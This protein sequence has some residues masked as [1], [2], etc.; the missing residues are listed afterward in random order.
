MA[1]KHHEWFVWTKDA[2]ANEAVSRFLQDGDNRFEEFTLS[3]A[4]CSDGKKRNLWRCTETQAY[5]LW[6]SAGLRIAIFNRLGSAKPKNVTFLFKKDR[7]STKKKK[8]ASHA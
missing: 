6:K 1:K 4:L 8:R 5:F 7:R 3:D 2:Q